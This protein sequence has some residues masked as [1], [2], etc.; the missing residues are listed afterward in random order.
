M[1]QKARLGLSHATSQSE[2]RVLLIDLWALN[3]V[4]RIAGMQSLEARSCLGFILK[5]NLWLYRLAQL[6]VMPFLYDLN[7]LI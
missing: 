3:L 4:G 6:Q 2:A 5:N 1:L 7:V